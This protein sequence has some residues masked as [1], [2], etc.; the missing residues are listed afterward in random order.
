MTSLQT[1]EFCRA[2]MTKNFCRNGIPP[3]SPDLA[4][5]KFCFQN[6]SLPYRDQ[7][8]RTL[9]TF[10]SATA[11]LR[12]FRNNSTNVTDSDLWDT[13][14]LLKLANQVM[15]LINLWVKRSNKPI[16]AYITTTPGTNQQ[17]FSTTAWRRNP[18][19]YFN[20]IRSVPSNVRTA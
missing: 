18:H 12:L 10:T 1:N 19:I 8:F 13:C 2:V 15:P 3:Y 17:I 20:E 9:Q 7:E 16:H 6:D 4:P 14:T 11:G 5:N